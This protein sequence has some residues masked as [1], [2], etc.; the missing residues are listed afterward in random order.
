M[1]MDTLEQHTKTCPTQPNPTLTL[2]LTL[3]LTLSRGG[4]NGH[5]RGCAALVVRRTDYGTQTWITCFK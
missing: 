4:V 2:T 5:E 3:S 1:S